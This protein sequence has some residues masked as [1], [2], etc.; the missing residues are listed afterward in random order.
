MENIDL[1][2]QWK[3]FSSTETTSEGKSEEVPWIIRS[4]EPTF[5]EKKGKATTI[6][7]GYERSEED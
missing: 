4:Q 5:E 7:E 6:I 3:S 2:D 1:Q